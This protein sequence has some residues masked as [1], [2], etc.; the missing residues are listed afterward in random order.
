MATAAKMKS[1]RA[2]GQASPTRGEEYEEYLD[3]F[4]AAIQ[5]LSD[6]L[7]QETLRCERATAEA[8]R[9]SQP[10]RK[11]L[12]LNAGLEEWKKVVC[13]STST[14][15]FAKTLHTYILKIFLSGESSSVWDC[16]LIRRT[17]G[18]GRRKC[19]AGQGWVAVSRE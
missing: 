15:W 16:R 14:L 17:D 1:V 4:A 8:I 10:A 2:T 5:N 12:A 3:G 18:N 6:E 9:R 11:L 19:M 13:T 7:Q